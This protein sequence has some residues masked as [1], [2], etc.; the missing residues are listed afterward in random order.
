MSH[1]LL[2]GYL[3]Q[4][5]IIVVQETW[6][7]ST[8]T[9]TLTNFVYY[10]FPRLLKNSKSKRSSGGIG[11]FVKSKFVSSV[12]IVKHF[13]DYIVWIKVDCKVVTGNKVLFIG[14]IYFPPVSS[15]YATEHDLFGLLVC[16]IQKY[17]KEG[18]IIL[19]GDFNARVGQCSEYSVTD[20]GKDATF[21]EN[22]GH[23][24]FNNDVFNQLKF[25][26]ANI[27]RVS[28][29]KCVN[30]YGRELLAL[31]KS[32]DLIIL[33]GRFDQDKHIGS[34][35]RVDTTGNSVVDYLITPI[36]N[37]NVV[38]SFKVGEKFPESE[39]LPL[40]FSVL[41]SF[42]TENVCRYSC[43]KPEFFQQYDW[44]KQSL[45]LLF[46]SCMAE[47]SHLALL[48]FRESVM[49]VENVNSVS[50]AFLGFMTQ[51]A[52]NV[53]P[54]KQISF[55]DKIGIHNIAPWFDTECK[56]LRNIAI[57]DGKRASRDP[58][59][60]IQSCKT[61]R[62]TKQRKK[63]QF[64]KQI[65][66]KL[67]NCNNI[68]STSVWNIL[69]PFRHNHSN[70]NYTLDEFYEAFADQAKPVTNSNWDLTYENSVLSFLNKYENGALDDL[71]H[72][73]VMKEIINNNFTIEE[74]SAVLS[75]LKSNKAAGLDALPAEFYVSIRDVIVED[76]TLLLNYVIENRN[77]PNSWATGVKIPVPKCK[78]PD[79]IKKY[80]Q[81]TI[82]PVICKIFEIAV[83]KRFV[84][85]NECFN[86]TDPYNGGF[87]Q[88]SSTS[89]NILI[90]LSCI[91]S[92][93]AKKSSLYVCFVDFTRAFD[94]I[95]RSILFYMY[96][97]IKS[98][99]NGKVV[100]TLRNLYTKTKSKVKLGSMLSPLLENTMGVNQGGI[101]SPFLFR[102]YLQDM[103]QDFKDEDGIK[104]GCEIIM[105]LLWA[106]DLVLMS[107]TVEGLQR[108]INRL[109]QYCSRNQLI[110]N[111]L[112]TKVMVFGRKPGILHFSF[113]NSPILVI[114]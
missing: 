30:S 106:D 102:K 74:I 65:Y 40:I 101:L 55:G 64:R 41:M 89:D 79:S 66:E 20:Y 45:P 67:E 47:A 100:D 62:A 26:K 5:N 72:N 76:I 98:G 94:L 108:Q 109:S 82:L 110:V 11:L 97:L 114:V 36:S 46:D 68:G 33:N 105:Y 32:S 23:Y 13:Y 50:D 12:S 93:L 81:I 103:S 61:Y 70:Y 24:D 52:D 15:V 113:E 78:N 69:K 92:Q 9:F 16:D 3:Q 39:H 14:I 58:N 71:C 88:G 86:M 57:A 111:T 112:K 85:V 17:S 53:F 10:N 75:N 73:S 42:S 56:I 63:R 48:R 107:E 8:A 34:Y 18:H 90:L 51:V 49:L 27:V 22:C 44:Y 59:K 43:I 80:R 99:F 38:N 104:L 35:T 31:C 6:A 19:C 2:G 95:N 60:I 37:I 84:F 28:R 87:L 21:I 91:Q 7:R 54:Q 1:N 83:L 77:I 29:D 25:S 4:F 96:K